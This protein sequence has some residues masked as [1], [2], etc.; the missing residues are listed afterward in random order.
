MAIENFTVSLVCLFCGSTLEGKADAAFASGD[1]IQCSQCGEGN[2]FDSVIEVA[3]EK[4]L[5][6]VK[7]AVEDEISKIFKK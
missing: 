7:A 1:L 4:G 5:Q 3:K 6:Q 2:D